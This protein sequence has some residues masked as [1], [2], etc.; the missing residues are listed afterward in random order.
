MMSTKWLLLKDLVKKKKK[1]FTKT[2]FNNSTLFLIAFYV[3]C[4]FIASLS[5]P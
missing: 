3:Y 2:T 5:T 4:I 1:T